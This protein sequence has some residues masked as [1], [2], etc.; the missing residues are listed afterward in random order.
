M[1][2]SAYLCL[3]GMGRKTSIFPCALSLWETPDHRRHARLL[4]GGLIWLRENRDP[5]LAFRYSCTN[6]NVRKK[7]TMRIDGESMPAR[8]ASSTTP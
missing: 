8:P 5:S 6:A 4:G 1:L 2:N 3:Q 7:C